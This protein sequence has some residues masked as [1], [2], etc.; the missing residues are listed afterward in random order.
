MWRKTAEYF[1]NHQERLKVA[2]VLVENGLNIKN[3]KIYCNEI[4]IPIKRIAQAAKVDRRTV[5]ETI[6]M[7]DKNEELRTIFTLMR[8]AGLSLKE[9]ARPLN[10]GVVEITAD[11]P[12]SVG[13][14]AGAATILANEGIS[15]RQA[16]TDD[17]ELSPEPRLTLIADRKIP[18]ELI[19]K[20]LKI[21][22]VAKVSIY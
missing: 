21:K 4:E 8:S 7:I 15:I 12:R 17:P 11:D 13:I 1:S 14:L 3:G 18:G 9:I 22:G 5:L 19:P 16:L 10:L 20:F 6:K 2:R